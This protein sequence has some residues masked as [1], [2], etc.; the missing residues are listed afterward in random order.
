MS[1]HP[2]GRHAAAKP[3]E[4]LFSWK[5]FRLKKE[6]YQRFFVPRSSRKEI[7]FIVG[8]QRSGTTMM[9][10]LFQRDR[11]ARLYRELS[12][13]SSRDREENLR[14]DPLDEVKRKIDRNR[15]GFVIAKPLVESQNVTKLLGHFEGSKAIWMVRHYEDVA[16]SNMKMFGAETGISDLRPIVDG[17]GEKSWRS[18][19]VTDETRRIVLDHFSEKMG[20]ADAAALFWYVRNRFFFDQELGRNERVLLCR[21][22][23]MVSDPASFMR[24]IYRFLGRD[25]PGD[26]I[27]FDVHPRSVKKGKEIGLSPDIKTLCENLWTEMDGTGA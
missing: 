27:V 2:K 11:S 19:K 20:N 18:E 10:V 21:Y 5:W 9:T 13:L 22:E 25:Y 4:S 12:E 26:R 15:T 3:A 8:C 7:L 1:G 17:L 14:F 6:I 16:A 24:K 23:E